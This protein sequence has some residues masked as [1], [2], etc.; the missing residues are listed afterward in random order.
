MPLGH[1]LIV[2]KTLSTFWGTVL[3]PL[4]KRAL[5]FPYIFYTTVYSVLEIWILGWHYFILVPFLLKKAP[6]SPG[7]SLLQFLYAGV[8]HEAF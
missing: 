3:V 6:F 2:H 8:C 4:S 7:G 1:R 5:F